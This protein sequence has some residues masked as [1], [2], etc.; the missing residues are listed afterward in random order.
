MSCCGPTPD[1]SIVRPESCMTHGTVGQVK[2]L[3]GERFELEA[4]LAD[5]G[6]AEA[7]R[8]RDVTAGRKAKLVKL[9]R[10]PRAAEPWSAVARLRRL[11]NPRIPKVLDG[12]ETADGCRWLAYEPVKGR[13]LAHWIEGHRQ[14]GTAPSPAMALRVFGDAAA[15]L[16]V[17]HGMPAPGVVHGGSSAGP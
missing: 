12:G 15:A 13:S 16:Q 17:G 2:E 3:L 8:A 5:A 14:A 4:P 11:G 10:P 7:W 6:L 9:F 1:R